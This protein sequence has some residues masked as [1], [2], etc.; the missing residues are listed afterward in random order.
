MP[1]IDDRAICLKFSAGARATTRVAKSAAS[2]CANIHKESGK[3]LQS[4]LACLL[5]SIAASPKLA[6]LHDEV[7]RLA[8]EQL[9]VGVRM[10]ETGMDI[11]PIARNIIRCR[12]WRPVRLGRRENGVER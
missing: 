9:Q 3:R 2:A 7:L 10:V 4:L 8:E 12:G 11:G 6:A 5:Y 1:V